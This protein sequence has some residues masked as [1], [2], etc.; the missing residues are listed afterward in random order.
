MDMQEE[1]EV[2]ALHYQQLAEHFASAKNFEVSWSAW[3]P[4]F[5]PCHLCCAVPQLAERYYQ[6]AELPQEAEGMYFGAGQWETAYRVSEGG[7]GEE[8]VAGLTAVLAAPQ[9]AVDCMAE[10]EL[11]Q[12]YCAK[13]EELEKDGKLRDAER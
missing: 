6:K 7:G 9:L 5:R 8:C 3:Q 13:G 2:E 11:R 4:C 1:G 12:R 10:E